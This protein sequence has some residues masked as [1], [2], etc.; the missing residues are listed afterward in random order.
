MK[1]FNINNYWYIQITEKGWDH[2]RK[3][4][5]ENYIDYCIL[6]RQVIINSI[7]YYRLQA[8]EVMS[9]LPLT[10]GSS[11]L[12]NTNILIDDNHLIEFNN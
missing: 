7:E 4:N 1:Q 10:F 3:T 8:H 12:Y 5:T 6:T 2:L 11:P 9:L